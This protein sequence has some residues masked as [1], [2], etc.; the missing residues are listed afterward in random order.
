MQVGYSAVQKAL[1]ER[2]AIMERQKKVLTYTKLQTCK[3]VIFKIFK[4]LLFLIIKVSMQEFFY[5]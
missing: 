5:D 3:N 4:I 1:D 2:R